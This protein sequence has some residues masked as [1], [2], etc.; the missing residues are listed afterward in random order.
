MPFA[1]IVRRVRALLG[2]R[3]LDEEIDEEFAYH[4]EQQTE[5]NVERGMAPDAA[6]AA[7]LRTFGGLTQRR[8]ECR[9]ARGLAF[10]D[11]TWQD[12][13][14]AL[15]TLAHSPGFTAVAVLSLALGI[16]ANTTIFAFV[17]AVLLRPLPYPDPDRLLIL[18]EQKQGEASTVQVHPQNYLEWKAR[19]KT[20]E[21]LTLVQTIPANVLAPDGAEQVTET[22]ATPEL[23][24]VFGVSPRLGRMFTN[25]EAAPGH[26]GEVAV[27][28]YEYW[29]RRF[30]AKSDVIGQAIQTPDGPVTIIGVAPPG[31]RIG[32]VEPDL[33]VPLPIDPAQPDAI[34][35]RSFAC[36]GRLRPEASIASVRAEMAV[37]AAGLAERYP[38]DRGYG[39]FV[40][41]LQDYL[42]AESRTALR[43]LMAV[44]AMV[45]VIACVNLAGLLMARGISRRS[46]LAVRAS[47]GATRSRL[48]R[49]LT[50]ESVTLAAIG[51]AAGLA[52]AYWSTR[53]LV[54]L[55]PGALTT[56]ASG[57]IRLDVTTLLFTI[58]LSLVTALAFGV[59]P[60]W[61][62]SRMEP[63][64]VAGRTRGATADRRHHR[65]RQVLVVAQ[66]GLAVV[67]LVGA[68]LLLRSFV[69]LAHVDPG[70]SPARTMTFRVFLG[71]RPDGERVALLERL[72]ERIRALPGVVAASS[73]Q[74][75][76]LTGMT[77][78]TGVW[79][80]GQVPGDPAQAA[81]TQCSL[82]SADFFEALQIPILEGRSL[83]ARDRSD[84]PRVVVVN[85]AFA[86]RYFPG[87]RAIGKRLILAGPSENW[88][89]VVGVAGDIRHEGLNVAPS[90]AV[91]QLHAQAPG[92]I[93][94]LIVRTDDRHGLDIPA[95]ERAIHEV[96]RTQAISGAKTMEQYLDDALLR[97]R[98]YAGLVA[99]FAG[100]AATL[101]LI[102]IYGLLAYVVGQRTHEIG[103]R[104]AL[105][106]RR[107]SVFERILFQALSLIACGLAI[108]VL[109]ALAARG[110]LASFLYG[111]TATDA[112]TYAIA[113]GAFVLVCVCVSAVPA[114][115]AST[116]NAMAALRYE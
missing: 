90:P 102:G 10:W 82:V 73:I 20:F 26:P 99:V 12:I 108:G 45:L 22:Q 65:A 44:V 37:I 101:A 25:Q 75:L 19:A 4:V 11:G 83:N 110:V 48:V 38:L 35:A 91:F 31:L 104:L 87:Q 15:R 34:G 8:E 66:V 16:G 100:L 92:Y 39:V 49:Q 98:L 62:A 33:I 69:S 76:P 17:N 61:Q 80:E 63:W 51:G 52:L 2:L 72:L 103:I 27:L 50:I 68:G 42:V 53:A 57:P 59:L 113:A 54:A 67:L 36:F 106:E 13:R 30:A 112:A 97:P 55:V 24:R 23:F 116:V 70:F 81:S 85:R 111:V 96:D 114:W 41:R 74:F 32:T 58:A 109:A 28:S 40:S 21:A 56:G 47:I 79:F 93:T 6:R 105:G 60:A 84:S 78:G 1:G 89:E 3:R 77:C 107:R 94:S 46:E 7:A 18:R 71:D 14:Y 9:D 86:R 29:V 43:L 95:I 5:A 115:R 64:A 88:A